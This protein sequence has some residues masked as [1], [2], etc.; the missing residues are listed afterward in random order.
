M[1]FYE[2]VLGLIAERSIKP[3]YLKNLRVME[4]TIKPFLK[5]NH[6]QY[7][8]IQLPS[9]LFPKQ[10]IETWA[11]HNIEP[12]QHHHSH[13]P[14]TPNPLIPIG[15]GPEPTELDQDLDDILPD[16]DSVHLASTRVEM[17]LVDNN[18][19]A[20]LT[21][22]VD[23]ASPGVDEDL[24]WYEIDVELRAWHTSME[25]N[26][27]LAVDAW[28]WRFSLENEDDSILEELADSQDRL[29]LLIQHLDSSQPRMGSL[30]QYPANLS[31]VR[32]Y[33]SESGSLG[34]SI[35]DPPA[36]WLQNSQSEDSGT[37]D[38][39]VNV[40]VYFNNPESDDS[41]Y[42]DYTNW[43]DLYTPGHVIWE[44]EGAEPQ[45]G[46]DYGPEHLLED[47]TPSMSSGPSSPLFP[48]HPQQMEPP[49]DI[50]VEDNTSEGS[51]LSPQEV[52]LPNCGC[53]RCN[54]FSPS[55]LSGRYS[56]P[57][58]MQEVANRLNFYIERSNLEV[59]VD[60]LHQ[61]ADLDIL[62]ALQSLPTDPLEEEDVR[63]AWLHHMDLQEAQ[64]EH[65]DINVD[66]IHAMSIA[67]ELEIIKEH[68][69]DDS[70]LDNIGL[71]TPASEVDV[72]AIHL[73]AE[74]E[75]EYI[76]QKFWENQQGLA[77]AAMVEECTRQHRLRRQGT[78]QLRSPPDGSLSLHIQPDPEPGSNTD[79]S[80][81][82]PKP[83]PNPP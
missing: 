27:W 69:H 50:E 51:K 82:L 3:V 78:N 76:K 19:R 24:Q 54:R 17:E 14:T 22:V 8:K 30:E 65:Y 35:H 1:T 64:Q 18:R 39:M 40:P 4:S 13:P 62:E 2:L 28:Q 44:E 66:H 81:S 77:T 37:D 46:S 31:P 9:V 32:G 72:D 60:S 74:A 21:D 47:S 16:I 49:P 55:T 80:P 42:L 38:R 20:P 23:L 36:F 53:L 52:H 61:Q 6:Q 67:A 34:E 83:W 63:S 43:L 5:H 25:S 15:E 11:L 10:E 58:D 7:S 59:Q 41:E 70:C 26:A 79:T 75:E 57:A 56:F 48:F 68:R 33:D 73:A 12:S 45:S 71:D 29:G